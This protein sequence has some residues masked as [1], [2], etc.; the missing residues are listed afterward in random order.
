MVVLFSSTDLWVRGLRPE[1]GAQPILIQDFRDENHLPRT[2]HWWRLDQASPIHFRSKEKAE[3][4]R[5]AI[6]VIA[7]AEAEYLI[8][9]AHSD[10]NGG[11]ITFGLFDQI[12]QESVSD[13]PLTLDELELWALS[14]TRRNFQSPQPLSSPQLPDR[15]AAQRLMFGG[16]P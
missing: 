10:S 16:A 2:R 4:V 1:A 7:A 3:F 6:G 15:H 11:P 13:R 8:V 12:L 9:R 5:R 14:F